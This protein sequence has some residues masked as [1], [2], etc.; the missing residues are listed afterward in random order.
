MGSNGT[1]LECDAI[2]GCIKI[3]RVAV[4]ASGHSHK[5][6]AHDYGLTPL[7]SQVYKKRLEFGSLRMTLQARN[8]VL[9]LVQLGRRE[10]GVGEERGMLPATGDVTVVAWLRQLA[11][12]SL[13]E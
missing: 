2:T 6:V 1:H 7:Q 11:L 9:A 12:D 4:A 8:G 10:G 5:A 3:E 13:E